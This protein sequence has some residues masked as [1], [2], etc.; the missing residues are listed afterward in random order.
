MRNR[1]HVG[2]V[3]FGLGLF[4]VI[5]LTVRRTS[6]F[7]CPDSVADEPRYHVPVYLRNVKENKDKDIVVLE[8][9]LKDER[10]KLSKELNELRRKL[11]QQD[12]EVSPAFFICKY[13]QDK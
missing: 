1:L 11:G 9:T 7:V 13:F 12:C 10:N 5:F 4:S 6:N 8:N 3:F 2:V